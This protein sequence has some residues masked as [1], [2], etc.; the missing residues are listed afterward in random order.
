MVLVN[1]DQIFNGLVLFLPK[2]L[3]VSILGLVRTMSGVFCTI[4]LRMF[5]KMVQI[6]LEYKRS[7]EL[8]T[9]CSQTLKLE[10]HAEHTLKLVVIMDPAPP[11]IGTVFHPLF[12][13]TLVAVQ[14]LATRTLPC[15]K[16]LD[17]FA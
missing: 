5:G 11:T 13:H 9:I 14:R 7:A 1:F 12:I 8:T 4:F 10:V 6:I 17:V 16:I 3:L 2:L 15:D